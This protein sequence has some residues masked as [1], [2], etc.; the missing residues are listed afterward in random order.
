MYLKPISM[1]KRPPSVCDFYGWVVLVVLTYLEYI[2][3]R[4]L[5]I[6][7][8]LFVKTFIRRF[9][10]DSCVCML[11]DP[12][13]V[14][15]CHKKPLEL[16]FSGFSCWL[17]LID[18]L[19]LSVLV[20]QPTDKRAKAAG[21]CAYSSRVER[22][23]P[24]VKENLQQLPGGERERH[25]RKLSAN[26]QKTPRWD[27]SGL[28]LFVS[29]GSDCHWDVLIFWMA[30]STIM[31]QNRKFNSYKCC[32][33]TSWEEN[34]YTVKALIVSI[35]IHNLMWCIDMIHNVI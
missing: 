12:M 22:L 14:N 3:E 16:M 17:T 31:V 8:D 30:L 20:Q 11:S 26:R 25:P 7:H 29:C 18:T 23:W 9:H 1:F 19:Y 5:L 28:F 6:N 24:G 32:S 21:C 13:I 2:L 35:H 15:F 34:N 10:S 27:Q 33:S 4:K